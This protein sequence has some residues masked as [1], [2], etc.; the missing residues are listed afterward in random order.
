[1]LAGLVLNGSMVLSRNR[2]VPK[3]RRRGW[4]AGGSRGVTQLV[5]GTVEEQESALENTAP[6][7]LLRTGRLDDADVVL[8]TR[9]NNFTNS[10][11]A[12]SAS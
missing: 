2:S 8:Q 7:M 5:F 3:K 11:T 12:A 4:P 10:A 9:L 6:G 1:M